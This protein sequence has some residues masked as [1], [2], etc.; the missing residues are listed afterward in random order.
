MHERLR[1]WRGR[2]QGAWETRR[3]LPADPGVRPVLDAN[4]EWLALAQDRSA[5]ADG[6]VARDYSLIRGWRPSYP[7]TTGYIVPTLLAYARLDG[8]EADRWRARAERMARWLA[9][10]QFD[11]GAFQGGRIDSTPVR[12][13]TFNTGQI[14]FAL[15]AATRA[16]GDGY[17]P[18]MRAAAD[19]LVATQHAD[20]AWHS[21]ASPFVRVPQ[22]KVYDTHVAW[23]LLEAARIDPGR[24]Y[25]EAAC[26]NVAWALGH[27]ADNGWF[28]QCC[29]DRNE[30]PLT[31][32]LGYALRGVIEAARFTGRPDLL[33]AARRTADGLLSALGPD[34]A[35]PGRLDSAWRPA[36]GWVCL[37][38]SA[39]VAACWL[40]LHEVTGDPTYRDAGFRANAYV[41]RTVRL[42]GPARVR[43][44][45]KGAHPISGDYGQ[46]EYL[47]WAAKFLADS[48]L[49]EGR[50]R[51]LW[52][53]GPDIA[54]L[55]APARAAPALPPIPAEAV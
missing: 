44:A 54:D 41:R 18:A 19:W 16:F 31:H 34:G 12:P 9:D 32:T 4:L 36:V 14:L 49:L 50:Q 37:T 5:S 15:V 21:N 22:A 7:E 30:A 23:A 46:F 43:G 55:P 17:L 10:I 13:V 47:N 26:A 25:A 39:Q 42:T 45:V 24:G 33:A 35:L 28:D 53:V 20:G 6:G 3:P 48:L 51:G 29:L 1:R 8:V 2:M 40:L 27:Q 38:G 11:D 52:T